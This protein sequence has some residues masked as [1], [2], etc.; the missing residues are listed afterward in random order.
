MGVR[1]SGVGADAGSMIG[2]YIGLLVVAWSV[3]LVPWAVGIACPNSLVCYFSK[4]A[5]SDIQMLVQRTRSTAPEV[6]KRG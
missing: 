6:R 4:T 1:I 2:Q 3:M 5:F